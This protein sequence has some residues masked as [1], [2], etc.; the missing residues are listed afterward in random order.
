M[1][2]PIYIM[3]NHTAAEFAYLAGI[4]DGDG[5]FYINYSYLNKDTG[6]KSYLANIEIT[7]TNKD[8][9]DWLVKTFGGRLYSYSAERSAKDINKRQ[10]HR[11][12]CSGKAVDYLCKSMKPYL[13]V[14]AK[15]VDVMINM[16]KTY[17][18]SNST[19]RDVNGCLLPLPKEIHDAREKCYVEMRSLYNK[20]YKVI[21]R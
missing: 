4:I 2:K 21:K 12:I 13:I 20:K 8:V 3:D 5:F 15:Q 16:R 18:E 7:N 9:I 1:A 14:K 19:S 17:L 10:V 11:W 6:Y